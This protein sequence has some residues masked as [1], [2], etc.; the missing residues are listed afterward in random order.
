MN[1]RVK[2]KGGGSAI[3]TVFNIK[4]NTYR[5][6]TIIEYQR[7]VIQVREALTHAEYSKD[8]WKDRL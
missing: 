5:L 8:S 2:L 1:Y 4:G 7:G 6:I 3:A